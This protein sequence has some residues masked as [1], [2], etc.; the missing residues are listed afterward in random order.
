MV[1]SEIRTFRQL[2]CDR[3]RWVRATH[4]ELQAKGKMNLDWPEIEIY[5]TQYKLD[6]KLVRAVILVESKGNH[7]AMRYEPKWRYNP[8]INELS[9]Y[10]QNIGASF[11]TVDMAMATSWGSMQVMG[12]VAYELGFRDWFPKLCGEL[13][14]KYGCMVIRRKIDRYGPDPATVYAAYNA[15]SPKLTPGGMFVNETNVDRFLKI[16]NRL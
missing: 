6:P 8:G 1:F 9:I 4:P 14:V 3:P 2:L 15:G 7:H 10:A 16:Y 5:S 13:G 12:A 11:S